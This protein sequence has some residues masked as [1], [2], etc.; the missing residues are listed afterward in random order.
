MRAGYGGGLSAPGPFGQDHQ[1]LR[2]CE[3]GCRP[4]GRL[5]ARDARG[6]DHHRGAQQRQGHRR[7]IQREGGGG[8]GARCAGL[9]TSFDIASGII[10]C[11]NRTDV[12][13]LNLSLGGP[14]STQIHSAVEY[15]VWGR[16]KLVVAAAG[17]DYTFDTTYAYPAA[18]ST[19]YPDMV[20]AV[21]AS[22]MWT[23]PDGTPDTFDEYNDYWCKADYSNYGNWISVVAPGSDILSTTP[24]D[25]P[26]Y[27]NCPSLGCGNP[28]CLNMSG[29]SMATP[30]VAAAAARR[31]G[32]KPTKTN[33]QIGVDVRSTDYAP[34]GYVY[35]FEGDGACWPAEME[36]STVNVAGLLE[37]GAMEAVAFD[38]STG[39][40]LNGATA[41]FYLGNPL[42]GS[43]V[44][45]PYTEKESPDQA[46]PTRIY[47]MVPELYGYHQPP[48]RWKLDVKTEQERVH[49]RLPE[50]VSAGRLLY[51]ERKLFLD[52]QSWCAAKID[53]YRC[54]CRVVEME[55]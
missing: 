32:F 14:Y 48:L 42:Q 20:L 33:G 5:R 9:G 40:P 35:D 51:Y 30:F 36:P 31:W 47:N 28:R 18:L 39:L 8:E 6:G 25:K 52:G 19:S 10:Y 7:G 16:N 3:R 46:D 2:L 27:M 41:G 44:I 12:K 15:A 21:A 34:S 1:G 13:V 17:N 55:C 49:Q 38:A 29:T 24:Y 54:R 11:A 4:D 22:G 23:D 43:A 53:E 45:T 50:R 37:R 26:F